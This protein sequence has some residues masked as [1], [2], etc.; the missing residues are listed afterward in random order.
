MKVVLEQNMTNE[1]AI[2][3]Y[4]KMNLVRADLLALDWKDDKFLSL[5]GRSGYNYLSIDKIK[6]NIAPV[7]QARGIDLGIEYCDLTQ[8]GNPDAANQH[9]IITLKASLI[10]I[11]TG[12]ERVY[13]AFGESSDHGDKGV[14]KAQTAAMKQFLSNTFLL[15]DGIDPD[16]EDR[17]VATGTFTKTPTETLVAKSKILGNAVK[18]ADVDKPKPEVK[19]SPPAPKAAPT[20]KSEEKVVQP[21]PQEEV[22]SE[23]VVEKAEDNSAPVETQEE[24]LK[25]E[26]ADVPDEEGVFVPFVAETIKDLKVT[27]PQ[28]SA[29]SRIID[30]RTKWAMEG[31]L[32]VAE[33]NAMSADYAGIVD[34]KSGA[35]FITKYRVVGKLV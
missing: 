30:V 17:L 25:K 11:S 2:S 13:T 35:D 18:P 33:Y 24:I 27:G 9:W 29:I 7:L 15:I 12:F 5:G 8:L 22:K 10:D 16:A 34:Q 23:P 21:T 14:N 3:F 28:R 32:S 4:T 26:M 31:K 6:R 20:P 1:E 19:V